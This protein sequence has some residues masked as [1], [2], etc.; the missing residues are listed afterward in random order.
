MV[1]FGGDRCIIERRFRKKLPAFK[2]HFRYPDP[3]V[4]SIQAFPS[5]KGSPFYDG[6]HVALV[7]RE[8]HAQVKIRSVLI[9]SV[10]RTRRLNVWNCERGME[11]GFVSWIICLVLPMEG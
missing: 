2:P 8:K 3:G 10:L 5:V 1:Y 4:E 11:F 9:L 7:L 6:Y